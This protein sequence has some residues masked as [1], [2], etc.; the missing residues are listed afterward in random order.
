MPAAALAFVAIPRTWWGAP[1][2]VV[3]LAANWFG[4]SLD[5]TL[6]RVRNQQRPRYGYYVDHAIDLAGT[7][8]L[9]IGIAASG[10]MSP[11]IAMTLLAAYLLVAAETYL[12]T[13]AVGVFRISFA[14]FG[15]TELRIVLAIG[16]IALASNQWIELGGARVLLFDVGGAIAIAGLVVVFVASVVRN[17]FDL[18][19]AEPLRARDRKERVA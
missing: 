12:A 5:G 16:G 7:A 9:L 14:G 6:A 2:L 11:V 13:H 19:R 18:Y 3:A 8:V 10:A 4:D 15:P 1:A 17:T